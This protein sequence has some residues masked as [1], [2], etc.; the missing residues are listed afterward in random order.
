MKGNKQVPFILIT[1]RGR[2]RRGEEGGRKEGDKA[3]FTKMEM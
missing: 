3:D 2:E 1:G